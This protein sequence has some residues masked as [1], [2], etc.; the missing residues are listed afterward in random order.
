MSAFITLIK[1]KV[2]KNWY[3]FAFMI[4]WLHVYRVPVEHSD[5]GYQCGPRQFCWPMLNRRFGILVSFPHFLMLRKMIWK[6]PRTFLCGSNSLSWVHF[7]SRTQL[8]PSA[9]CF[10]CRMHGA[11]R[12][13]TH[14]SCHLLTTRHRNG[15]NGLRR[16]ILQHGPGPR[17][18]AN[19]RQSLH[20]KAQIIPRPSKWHYVT[21][22]P[23]IY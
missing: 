13:T 4:T 10:A 3:E 1:N 6:T 22:P 16:T 12:K 21:K 20:R 8:T 5:W 2:R 19:L 18:R 17:E 14:S 11:I 23:S 9:A 15:K 7:W